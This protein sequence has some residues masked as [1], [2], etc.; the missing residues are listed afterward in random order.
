MPN[1][2][3]KPTVLASRPSCLHLHFV[4]QHMPNLA[5]NA[6][7]RRQGFARAAVAGYLTR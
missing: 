3:L 6:D 1:P 2:A 4:E 7:T 5:V